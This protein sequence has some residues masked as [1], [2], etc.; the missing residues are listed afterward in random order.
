M[1]VLEDQHQR[2]VEA[3]AQQDA[4]DRL[5]RPAPF[6]LR[7]HLGE[8]IFAF[9]NAEQRKQVRQRVFQRTIER[10]GPCR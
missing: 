9:L 6:D 8:R 2:L 3:L 1:Q 4:L 10:P 7:I 5:Q